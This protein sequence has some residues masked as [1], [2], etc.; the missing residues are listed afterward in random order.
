MN[1]KSW[2]TMLTPGPGS[3]WV[4]KTGRSH[5][6]SI[7][8]GIVKIAFDPLYDYWVCSLWLCLVIC[9]VDVWGY[10]YF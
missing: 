2:E 10:T 3:V 1:L 4:I 7:A 5:W 6:M 9:S 8:N